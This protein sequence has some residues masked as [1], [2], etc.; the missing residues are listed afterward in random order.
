MSRSRARRAPAG[1]RFPARLW[2]AL[3]LGILVVST[4]ASYL[5]V[6]R[7]GFIQDDHV[8]YETNPIVARGDLREIFATDYWAGA[9]GGDRNLYR[10]VTVASWALDV[11]LAGGL[12]ARFAH[13]VNLALHVLSSV[14]LFCL[15][16]RAGAGRFAAGAAALLFAL[17][18]V[19]VEAVA[20]LVGRAEILATL[21][22]FVA[23]WMYLQ[24]GAVPPHCPAEASAT[25]RRVAAWG[26]AFAVFCALGSKEIAVAL[27]AL[28]LAADLLL[29]P[30]VRGAA[31]AWIVQRAACLAPTALAI[32]VFSALRVRAL[33]AWLPAQPA[34]P[35]DNP[36]VALAGPERL[37]T[38]LGLVTRYVGLFLFPR[39]LSIDYS[40]P[41]IPIEH[42]PTAIRPLAG[43]LILAGL[44]GLAVLPWITRFASREFA[45]AGPFRSSSKLRVAAFAACL[46]LLPYA[47]VSNLF[48]AIG[49]IF[50][51]RLVYLPSAGLCLL[52]GVALSALAYDYPAFREWTEDRRVRYTT[53]VLAT[54]AAAFAF[55]TFSRATVWQSDRTVFRAAA[56]AYPQSPRAQF[57]LG[58]LAAESGD[59]A[60]A[61]AHFDRALARTPSYVAAAAEA[62]RVL[63]GLGRYD[64]AVDRLRLAIRH[65]PTHAEAHLHLG[66]ALERL[67]RLDEAER[68]LRRAVLWNPDLAK[69]WAALGHRRFAAGRFDDAAV[70]YGRAVALGRADLSAR[71]EES[72][73]RARSLESPSG[74]PDRPRP[75][76]DGSPAP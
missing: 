3:L 73:Q 29:R 22:S 13:A 9:T 11:R 76:P 5:P 15:A 55:Q 27:P 72:R 53:V 2:S 41:V 28:L 69:G 4:I 70:A 39:K 40:G 48:V 10:P 56:E 18:P 68:S 64:E 17:H 7:A 33:G 43:A 35:I 59:T 51:E 24:T 31:G 57:V 34:H 54:L 67:G 23:I 47:V 62:G 71:L 26:T 61:L 52:G 19:H 32:T 25:S 16:V 14:A 74:S 58:T 49:T 8:A 37:A 46:F 63:G 20:G 50:A 12:S 75:V 66:L 21:F 6:G 36:L 65:G 30:P 1:E 38:A 60:T 45:A 44:A 42:S